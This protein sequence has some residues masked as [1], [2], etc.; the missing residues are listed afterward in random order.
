M[1]KKPFKSNNKDN[2]KNTKTT[3]ATKTTK[4]PKSR[5]PYSKKCGACQMIDTPYKKQLAIKK[6][7]VEELVGKYGKSGR[8]HRDG[9]ALALQMQGSCCFYT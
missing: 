2:T 9:R 5:C 8:L 3:K 6:K 1:Y 7:R 4:T